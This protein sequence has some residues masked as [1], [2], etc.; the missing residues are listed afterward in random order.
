MPVRK[1]DRAFDPQ[2]VNKM[3]QTVTAFVD[4]LGLS[5]ALSEWDHIE[6]NQLDKD[7]STPI[8]QQSNGAVLKF[9]Q[10]IQEALEAAPEY[11]LP[12]GSPQ[13]MARAWKAMHAGDSR[14]YWFSD[15]ALINVIVDHTNPLG[16]CYDVLALL[17]GLAYATLR[18]AAYGQLM[19][20][21]IEMGTGLV[22]DSQEVLGSGLVA[23]HTLETSVAKHP[24]ICL[25]PRFLQF[26]NV[27]SS[28]EELT[29]IGTPPTMRT[30]TI[31]IAQE[32]AALV[33]IDED[34]LPRLDFANN[35]LL[36]DMERA[37]VRSLA[38]HARRGVEARLAKLPAGTEPGVQ[39]KYTWMLKSL[40]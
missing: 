11:P 16:T 23:A 9:R 15:C 10:L 3:R 7:R 13:D 18:L 36:S 14:V 33:R 38:Q 22:S 5:N 1:L 19:R 26:L 28:D 34:N 12:V 4:L 17:H 8:V 20:G 2:R 29:R 32:A 37:G 27:C 25:G 35:E 39:S 24:R 40:P 21:G 31:R 6:R 30:M